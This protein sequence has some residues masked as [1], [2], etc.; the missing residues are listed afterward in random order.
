MEKFGWVVEKLVRICLFM[1]L[2]Y[3]YGEL[4]FFMGV[5]FEIFVVFFGI[6]YIVYDEEKIS[7]FMVY[8]FMIVSSIVRLFK[9]FW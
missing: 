8:L 4:G 2:V 7:C 9:L 1:S 6:L 3:L 5:C